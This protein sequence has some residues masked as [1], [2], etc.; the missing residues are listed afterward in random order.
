MRC[1]SHGFAA[2]KIARLPVTNHLRAADATEGAQ[3]RHEVNRFKNVGFPLRIVA[4]NE[5]EARLEIHIQPRVVA[6][7][8]KSQLSQMHSKRMN[9]RRRAR[10]LF[11]GC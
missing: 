11:S 1:L 8:A 10:E 5:V 3:R 2:D 6:E 7:V 4:K 9:V